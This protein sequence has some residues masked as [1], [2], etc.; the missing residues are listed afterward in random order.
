MF[1]GLRVMGEAFGS[2]DKRLKGDGEAFGS[3]DKRLKG[4]EKR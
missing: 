1:N 4:D 2:D 3:D